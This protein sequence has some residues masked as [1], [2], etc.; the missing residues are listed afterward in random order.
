MWVVFLLCAF[1]TG[2]WLA[3]KVLLTKQVFSINPLEFFAV[4]AACGL[5]MAIA[6][7]LIVLGLIEHGGVS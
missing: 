1:V 2:Y 3:G 4:R 7:W 6:A 5:A